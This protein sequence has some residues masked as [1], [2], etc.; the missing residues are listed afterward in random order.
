MGGIL[1]IAV[2][3]DGGQIVPRGALV[4]VRGLFAR[5][6]FLSSNTGVFISSASFVAE[7]VLHGC[8]TC[9]VQEVLSILFLPLLPCV[10]CLRMV[11]IWDM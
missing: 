11:V 2:G 6:G 10:V 8:E 4:F 7:S 9:T 3:Y 1:L 5:L